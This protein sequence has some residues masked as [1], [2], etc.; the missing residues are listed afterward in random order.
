[1]SYT[2]E[3]IPKGG[4]TCGVA[5]RTNVS[6]DSVGESAYDPQR[7]EALFSNRNER[8]TFKEAML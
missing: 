8:K 1:M 2:K 3:R 5:A 7:S 6:R 4:E